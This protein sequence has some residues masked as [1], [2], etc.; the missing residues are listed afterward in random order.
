MHE[1]WAGDEVAAFG[2]IRLFVRHSWMVSAL[3]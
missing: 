1:W 3:P 2:G